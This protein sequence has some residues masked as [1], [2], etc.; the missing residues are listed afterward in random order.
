MIRLNVLA[1]QIIPS[2][3]VIKNNGLIAATGTAAIWLVAAAI[4]S[5]A[6]PLNAKVPM[7]A[8][9]AV[10]LPIVVPIAYLLDR[11]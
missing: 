11:K 4:T 9:W 1:Q 6:A 2:K 8:L 7:A 10:S 5:Q 3:A